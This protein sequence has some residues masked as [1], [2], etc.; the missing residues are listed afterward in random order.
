M[1]ALVT[2]ASGFLGLDLVEQLV[3]RGD[4]VRAF[5]R[6]PSPELEALGVETLLGDVRDAEATAAACQRIDV[7][8]HVAAVAG[9]WGPW[10]HFYETNTLGTRHVIAG[11]LRHGVQK[12]VYTSSPSVTFDGQEQCGIDE[13]APYPERWLCHYPHTKALAEQE[14]LAANGRDGLLTCALRPHLIWG[15]RDRQLVPRVIDRARQKQLIRVGDGKN[16]I[17]MVFVE[18]AALAHLQAADCLLPASPV[19]GSAYFISQGEP[20]NCWHWIDGLLA[21]A[22][23]PA[24]QRSI[25]TRA[26]YSIGAVL[27]A[28]YAT[29]GKVEEPRM[30]RFLALQLGKSHYFSIERA[31]R[32]FGYAPRVT[33]AEGMRRLKSKL[34]NGHGP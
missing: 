16:L 28:G 26:A 23:L 29:L 33:T 5:C 34:S 30:T 6:R 32:D 2:G 15:P 14:V 20:V 17:D 22:G 24:V 10:K 9:I 27:E 4:C 3:A 11:C 31:R 13:S 8:F 7:V 19:A 12:L 21:L 1:H 18:N 25:S